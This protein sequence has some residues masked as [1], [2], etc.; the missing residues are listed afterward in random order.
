MAQPFANF[1]FRIP[2]FYE[3]GMKPAPLV[4]GTPR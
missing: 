2:S 1:A 3:A 4:T